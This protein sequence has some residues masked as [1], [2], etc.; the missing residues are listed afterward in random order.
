MS[1]NSHETD[2]EKAEKATPYELIGG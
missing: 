2:N 1:E